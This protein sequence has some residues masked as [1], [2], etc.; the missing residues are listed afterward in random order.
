MTLVYA[1]ANPEQSYIASKTLY[2]IF[3]EVIFEK[4]QLLRNVSMQKHYNHISMAED[5]PWQIHRHVNS[6]EFS[7]D[8]DCKNRMSL[9][10]PSHT[11]SQE[12][13]LQPKPA[14][15]NVFR[16]QCSTIFIFTYTKQKLLLCD[17]ARTKRGA[18]KHRQ[19]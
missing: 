8:S 5:L 17:T 13:E 2:V 3:C 6:I 10:F 12:F 4:S 15:L 16:V 19:L 1:I 18:S 11:N 7:R 9:T 14:H